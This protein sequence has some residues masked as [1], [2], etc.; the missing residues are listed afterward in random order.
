[1]TGL[2]NMRST[3]LL[4]LVRSS[5]RVCVTRRSSTVVKRRL[6]LLRILAM[7]GSSVSSSWSPL[8]LRT[9][10]VECVGR[11]PLAACGLGNIGHDLHTTRNNSGRT[12]ATSG[13][14]RCCR[15]TKS[16]SQLLNQCTSHIIRRNMDGVRDT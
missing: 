10:A 1:M 14:C 9:L 8:R 2:R 6:R 15:T 11:S 5:A 13:I 12:T 4:G 7:H 16:L 3:V